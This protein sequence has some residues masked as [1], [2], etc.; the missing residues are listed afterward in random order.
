[1]IDPYAFHVSFSCMYFEYGYDW[2]HAAAYIERC[3][4]TGLCKPLQ[5]AS[6]CVGC[7][8]TLSVR[9][10]IVNIKWHQCYTMAV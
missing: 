8:F 1:M 4:C 3:R 6:V 2:M 10:R 5:H 7:T 9:G